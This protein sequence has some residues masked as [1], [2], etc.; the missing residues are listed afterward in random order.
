MSIHIG[1]PTSSGDNSKSFEL[2]G[3]LTLV[4]APTSIRR[5]RQFVRIALAARGYE[6]Q[7]AGFEL[8]A[9]ELVT[10][11][12]LHA[13]C[14]ASAS[15]PLWVR[16]LAGESTLR[17]EVHDPS[18]CFPVLR[19]VD[20]ESPSGRGLHIV[21]ALTDCMGTYLRDRGSGKVVWC[22]W[23]TLDSRRSEK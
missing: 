21:D 23:T 9:S 18:V 8:V 1:R 12:V 15:A 4:S 2:L 11:A 20:S 16:L 5:A 14:G 6:S 7:T 3:S 13:C 19:P 17:L 10:N 22:E